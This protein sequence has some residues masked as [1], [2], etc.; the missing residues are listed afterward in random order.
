MRTRLSR[1]DL[2]A[3]DAGK[4]SRSWGFV[5]ASILSLL[6]PLTASCG[7]AIPKAG[8]PVKMSNGLY[9]IPDFASCTIWGFSEEDQLILK[10]AISE[11]ETATNGQISIRLDNGPSYHCEIYPT[12]LC[13]LRYGS[14]DRGRMTLVT[15]AM[16]MWC[17][18]P[19]RLEL[20]MHEIGHALG[21][22]HTDTG[23]MRAQGWNGSTCVDEEALLGFCK[24]HHCNGTERPTCKKH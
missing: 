5:V 9:R 24:V 3:K 10:Y 15:V 16:D 22:D 4:G 7:P 14:T 13:P 12:N 6:V 18:G 11:W 17:A 2:S 8:S 20:A 1:R 21:V 19:N 23:L